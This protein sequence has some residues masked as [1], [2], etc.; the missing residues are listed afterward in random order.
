MKNLN[1]IYQAKEI[2]EQKRKELEEKIEIVYQ[3]LNEQEKF[4]F[5]CT[6]HCIVRYLQRVESVPVSKARYLIRKAVSDYVKEHPSL[7]LKPLKNVGYKLDI[8]GIRY[9]IRNKKIVTVEIP[10]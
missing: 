9:V 1:S 5:T 7:D 2:L 4:L 6:D 8:Q 3:L 10:D